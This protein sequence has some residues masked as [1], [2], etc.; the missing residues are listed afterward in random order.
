MQS[1]RVEEATGS[2][3]SYNPLPV[4]IQY[5]TNDLQVC[6]VYMRKETHTIGN[7]LKHHLLQD[8]ALEFV[9][10][11][12]VHPP[13]IRILQLKLRQSS[14]KSEVE[15]ALLAALRRI[16]EEAAALRSELA[17]QGTT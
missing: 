11:G 14:P 9:G 7:L 15:P 1:K 3:D 10:C 16:R 12:M 5:C 8:P 4:S 2:H 13:D 6:S 17:A